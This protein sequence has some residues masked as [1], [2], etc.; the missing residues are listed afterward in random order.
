MNTVEVRHLQALI[1][2]AE[3]G[4]FTDA[5]IRLGVTQPA[6]SRLINSFEQLVDNRLIERTTRSVALTDAGLQAY[7]AA[8]AAVAAV[9]AVLDAARGEARPL[10]LGFAWSALGRLTTEVLQSWRTQHPLVALEVHRIDERLA[11][12]IRGGADIAVIR[13]EIDTAGI[14]VRPIFREARMAAVPIAHP[15][16]T[17]SG[18]A[19]LDLIDETVL[20][21]LS[22]TT[23][24]DLWPAG[25][26]PR[27]TLRV[28]NIDE[29]ITEIA[30]GLAVGVTTESTATQHAH[31][32]IRFIPLADAP[33][34]TV[35]LAW[36]AQHRHPATDEFVALVER[37][38]AGA[39]AGRSGATDPER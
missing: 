5:A 8:V 2:V 39:G 35:N 4:T 16:A 30:G 24:L 10:R 13:G 31:P 12:L 29:W 25:Q 21:T 23:T 14:V 18:V 37:I 22:G 38:V 34:V 20:T 6:V 3:E 15:L 1:A 27:S 32:G 11:G 26:Q 33:A 36:P 7:R 17:R 28:D 9:Q 19:L